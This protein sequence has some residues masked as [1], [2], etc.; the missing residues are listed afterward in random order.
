MKRVLLTFL[1]LLV[2]TL[3][4]VPVYAADPVATSFSASASTVGA[5]LLQLQGS[6]PDSTPLVFSI[7]AGPSHGTLSGL[8]ASTGYVIYTPTTAY[9]GADSFTF[10]VTSGGADSNTATVSLTVTNAK[11]RI[12]D[13]VVDAAGSPRSGT[14]TFILTQ[15][16]TSPGG[17]IP[18]SQ[19]VSDVLDGSG[20]FDVSVY[21]STALTPQAYYQVWYTATGSLRRELLGVY[22]IP[23]TSAA[24]ITLAAYLVTNTNLSAQYNFMPLAAINAIATGLASDVDSF[25][26]R[27]GAVVPATNDYT[28]A[29]INKATSSIADITTRSAADLNSGQLPM[30][31]LGSLS[32]DFIPYKTSS[33]LADTALK[34]FGTNTV[35]FGAGTPAAPSTGSSLT[36]TRLLLLDGASGN[37][38]GIG[39]ESGKLWYN[40]G[41]AN[42]YK[43]YWGASTAEHHEIAPSSYTINTSVDS[44]TLD[45][46]SS[47]ISAGALILNTNQGTLRLQTDASNTGAW[48]VTSTNLKPFT[49][50]QVDIGDSTNYV[51]DSYTKNIKLIAD[52]GTSTISAGGSQTNL[53]INFRTKGTGASAK[54]SFQTGGGSEM[55]LIDT[56]FGNAYFRSVIG[57]G[58]P[59]YFIGDSGV[60][61]NNATYLGFA[62]GANALSAVFEAAFKKSAP[63]VIGVTKDGTVGGTLA[64]PTLSPAQITSN[65]DNYNP[66]NMSHYLRLNT[67]ASRNIT[68]LTFATAQ[69]DGQTH[70]IVNVG[71]TDI[72]LKHDTTSTAA[73]RFLNSTGADITLTANQMAD[74]WYDA[75]TQR[76]R[77]SKRN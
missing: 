57:T 32:D 38:L 45:F 18:T 63:G 7:V 30:A 19:T 56:D 43:F 5:T 51:K 69:V 37:H 9:T 44:F 65:Q 31:R 52:S 6:D 23:A 2:L 67:D 15:K 60:R 3:S 20:Q 59:V 27:I 12:V 77:V 22:A 72:V 36:G 34:R 21:P 42:T 40:V 16:A 68:G 1:I 29:Q 71:S 50:N 49:G 48:D 55:A 26:G 25:N 64:Y 61:V 41:A 17:I 8:E 14:V 70:V 35:G 10:K 28:W 11:T 54:F 73:N 76:W 53:G 24:S 74:L 13:T 33:A 47:S 4:T 58:T 66:G 75:T 39:V 62:D 46:Q